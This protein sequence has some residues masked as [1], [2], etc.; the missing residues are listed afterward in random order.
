MDFTEN[1]KLKKPSADDF[2]D[3]ADLNANADTIDEQMK[4][5]A[6]DLA[7]ANNAI[8][9]LQTGKADKSDIG[10]GHLIVSYSTIPDINPPQFPIGG[11]GSTSYPANLPQDITIAIQDTV[12]AL[13]GGATEDEPGRAGLVPAP[14]I[15]AQTRY[16]RGDGDWGNP[17]TPIEIKTPN[18]DANTYTTSGLYMFLLG[19]SPLNAPVTG[20]NGW[21]LV[22]KYVPNAIKQ[23]WFTLGNANNHYD[24]F[25]RTKV[26]ANWLPWKKIS[27]VPA[28]VSPLQIVNIVQGAQTQS[29]GA[30]NVS[31]PYQSGA[32]KALVEVWKSVVTF[33]ASSSLNI[34]RTIYG[35]RY[36]IGISSNMTEIVLKAITDL[37]EMDVRVGTDDAG[38]I[39]FGAST[40]FNY[41]VTWLV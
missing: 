25:I 24:T 28:E 11:G 8:A 5:A 16:L 29:G 2:A 15:G 7:A 21:L 9:A 38:R 19:T 30:Q 26:G 41:R 13:M 18:T 1:Y 3:V 20:T 34:G 23:I 32:T 14:P 10:T 17:L 39:L 33:V 4:K 27:T 35:S 40:P 22:S 37:S 6:D 31:I 12:Y 36:M